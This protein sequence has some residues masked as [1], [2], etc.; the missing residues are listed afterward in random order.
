MMTYY[1]SP[2]RRLRPNRWMDVSRPEVHIPVDVI[3]EDDDYVLTAFVPGIEPEDV[4]IEILEDS[5]SISGE[6]PQI[7]DEDVSYLLRERP[8][9]KFSRVLRM[10]ASLEAGKG[11]ADVSN[12]VLTLRVP[13]AE[14]AK[15]K[16][17]AVK[18]K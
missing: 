17:I 6:F 3:V 5:I 4:E 13:K 7:E 11:Q 14:S 8:S 15:A 12:G 16:K 9:G 2:S 10:P 18:V 1:L